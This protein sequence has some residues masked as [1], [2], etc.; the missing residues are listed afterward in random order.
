M[1]WSDKVGA[2]AGILAGVQVTDRASKPLDADGGFALWFE[3]ACRVRKERRYCYLIGNGASA[4]MASHFAA[5]V[6][7]NGRIFTQVFTDPS[8]VTALGNDMGYEHVFAEPIRHRGQPGDLL[9]AISSSGKSP[10]VLNAVAAAR[11]KGLFLVTLSAMD[12]QN[13]LRRSGD[14]NFWVDAKTYGNAETSHAT[15]LHHWMDALVGD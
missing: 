5:D 6:A 12:S 14:L 15:I 11:E 8:L 3:E 9:I 4:S 10:N 13:P 2:L 7:K 1:S